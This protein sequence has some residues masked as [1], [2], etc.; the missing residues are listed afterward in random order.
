MSM[1]KYLGAI[2]ILIPFA[3]ASWIEAHWNV[4]AAASWGIAL[5]LCL[6]VHIGRVIEMR[7]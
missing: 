4:P 1:P 6:S 7:K 3:G 2:L 5:M